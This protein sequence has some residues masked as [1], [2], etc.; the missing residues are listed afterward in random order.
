MHPPVAQESFVDEGLHSV[1]GLQVR[2]NKG[3]EQVQRC[4]PCLQL[5]I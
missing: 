2:A 1:E 5:S 3:H 4:R